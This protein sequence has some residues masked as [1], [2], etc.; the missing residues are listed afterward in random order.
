MDYILERGNPFNTDEP[1]EI[2]NI[3]IAT[4]EKVVKSKKEKK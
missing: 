1:S 2:I 3:N 4:G